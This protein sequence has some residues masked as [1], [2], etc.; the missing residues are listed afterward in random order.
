MSQKNWDKFRFHHADIRINAVT[1]EFL[2]RKYSAIIA[3][4]SDIKALEELDDKFD[5]LVNVGALSWPARIRLN[6][7]NFNRKVEVEKLQR[8]FSVQG[9][10]AKIAC[11]TNM[12]DASDLAQEIEKAWY[13][14]SITY[15]EY[16][17]VTDKLNDLMESF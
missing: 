5:K 6:T 16:M 9:T 17:L 14:T 12:E 7:L 11:V 4:T 13:T 15:D 1:S 10:L 3:D 2:I 8:K